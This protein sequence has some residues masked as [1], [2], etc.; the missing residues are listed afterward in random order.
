MQADEYEYFIASNARN[1]SAKTG[2]DYESRA[3][4]GWLC[5]PLFRRSDRYDNE[6]ESPR[7][8]R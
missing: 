5:H 1:G 3:D 8:Q 6:R 2:D 7:Y 4:D